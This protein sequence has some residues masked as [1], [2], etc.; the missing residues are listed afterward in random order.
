MGDHLFVLLDSGEDLRREP[1]P[2]TDFNQTLTRLP[3]VKDKN[4]PVLSRTE[5]RAVGDLE[6]IRCLQ[7]HKMRF[8]PVSISQNAPRVRRRQDV[9]DNQHPLFLHAKTGYLCKSGGFD[10]PHDSRK[11]RI[12]A[13]AFEQQPGFPF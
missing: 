6:N 11:R 12:A 13:P 5:K 4:R 2:L 8:Q 9:G 7:D 10:N 1:V 3:V